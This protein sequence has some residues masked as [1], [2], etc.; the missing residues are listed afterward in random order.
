[1]TQAVKKKVCLFTSFND[2]PSFVQ[3]VNEEELESLLAETKSMRGEF[4][5]FV[6]GKCVYNG[7]LSKAAIEKLQLSLH[8]EIN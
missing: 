3:Y 8:Y 1:M 5:Q 6:D 2:V 4:A 7:N